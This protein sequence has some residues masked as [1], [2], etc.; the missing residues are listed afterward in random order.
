M[1]LRITLIV[2]EDGGE[3]LVGVL[4]KGLG[5]G[6]LGILNI[7]IDGDDRKDAIDTRIARARLV[8]ARRHPE[9]LIHAP[10]LDAL[11]NR[12][13]GQRSG[14]R[15]RVKNAKGKM[16]LTDVLYDFLV[17]KG[18]ATWALLR[19]EIVKYGFAP[20]SI[21]SAAVRLRKLH[22]DVQFEGGQYV[23][24]TQTEGRA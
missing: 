6:E 23:V 8:K 13:P 4:A 7:H 1:T 10:N 5:R 16:L 21:N 19:A 15:A 11:V 24:R 22:P 2:D 18:P 14:P 3:E 12:L 20:T 17:N 9:S